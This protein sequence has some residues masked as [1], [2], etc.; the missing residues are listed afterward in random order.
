MQLKWTKTEIN[1]GFNQFGSTCMKSS[2]A[3]GQ[4]F[5]GTPVELAWN[6]IR[7]HL[8]DSSYMYNIVSNFLSTKKLQIE[9]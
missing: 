4:F 8:D 2:Y 5:L 7:D 6:P 1:R 3:V 9:S